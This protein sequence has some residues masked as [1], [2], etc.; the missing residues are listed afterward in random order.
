[1]RSALPRYIFGK[2]KISA[3]GKLSLN[4]A[5]FQKNNAHYPRAFAHL[6]GF[7]SRVKVYRLSNRCVPSLVKVFFIVTLPHQLVK[8]HFQR[9]IYPRCGVC[10]FRLPDD[11]NATQL[12]MPA[13]TRQRKDKPKAGTFFRWISSQLEK[14]VQL[15]R[16]M[17][18]RRRQK[19]SRSII[20]CERFPVFFE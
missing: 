6:A 10:L 14:Q 7:R 18:Q 15:S 16:Q 5:A 2:T 13:R 1:M 8:A 12:A 9:Y 3:A 4:F 20:F 17:F 19:C 11:I